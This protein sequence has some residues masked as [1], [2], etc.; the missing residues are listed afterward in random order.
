MGRVDRNKKWSDIKKRW[1]DT[2]FNKKS[3]PELSVTKIV[4]QSDEWCAEAYMETDYS[5]ITP[6]DFEKTLKDYISFKF[7]NSD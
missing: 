3:I 4:N 2:Y 5:K 7:L 1:L 6:L